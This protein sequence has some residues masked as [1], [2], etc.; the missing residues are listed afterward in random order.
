M[1]VHTITGRRT[2]ALLAGLH[3]RSAALGHWLISA[4]AWVQAFSPAIL[5]SWVRRHKL[6]TFVTT[7]FTVIM[8]NGMAHVFADPG[9]GENTTTDGDPFIA[10][11]G[12]KDTHNVPVAKYTLTLNQGGWNDASAAVFFYIDSIVYEAYLC[13]TTTALWLIKF[14]LDFEWL[15]LFTVPFQTIGNGV[16]S[17]VEK[18]GLAPTAMAVLA[19]IAV[20]TFLSGK[21]AKAMSQIGMALVITGVAA[22]IF[23]NPLAEMVGPDGLLAKGRDTGLEIAVTVSGGSLPANG[24]KVNPEAI[25]SQ[26]ADRFLR[27]PTQMINFGMVSDSISRKCEEAWSKGIIAG[28]GD[29]L[30]DDIKGCGEKKNE[31][32][33]SKKAHKKSMDNPASILVGLFMIAMLSCFLVA[34]ACYFAWHVVRTAVQA[35]LFAA[36]A[37]PAFVLAVIPGGPQ[38]F[39]LKTVLDCAMA[40]VAMIIFTAAFGGYNVILDRVFVESGSNAVRAIFMTS[41]VLAIGFAFFGPLRRM[42]DRTRDALAAKVSGGPELKSNG[43]MQKALHT[44]RSAISKGPVGALTDR[45]KGAQRINTESPEE[46][47]NQAV[48]AASTSEQASVDASVESTGPGSSISSSE[49]VAPASSIQQDT[50]SGSSPVNLIEWSGH[51]D[52]LATA[53]RIADARAAGTSSG[54]QLYVP[55]GSTQRHSMAEAA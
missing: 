55:P 32:N 37:P 42:F 50:S 18:F 23:A 4:H 21:A 39:A 33:S 20:F 2:R 17:A 52:R 48:S 40:Y 9:T 5:L 10:W 19:F 1:T 38:T 16:N 13:V 41:L 31:K 27:S 25:V 45:S 29:K 6:I 51:N 15:K 36:L 8:T 49:D 12:I 3:T 35:M 24:N 46:S 7:T 11:M 34:F 44:A 14:V 30:K 47:S 43:S 53:Q 26:L 28:H 22:S 54:P